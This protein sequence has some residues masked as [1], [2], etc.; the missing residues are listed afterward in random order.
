[1]TFG[2]ARFGTN[3][4][5]SGWRTASTDCTAIQQSLSGDSIYAWTIPTDTPKP[6][7]LQNRKK[8]DFLPAWIVQTLT[9]IALVTGRQNHRARGEYPG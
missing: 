1:M 3:G 6:G 7:R 2:G 8:I 5:G 9:E 4:T